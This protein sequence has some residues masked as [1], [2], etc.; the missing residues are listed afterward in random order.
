MEISILKKQ[1]ETH[2][3]NIPEINSFVFSL[4]EKMTN[5]NQYNQKLVQMFSYAF[6]EELVPLQ[7]EQENYFKQS[8]YNY[9]LKINKQKKLWESYNM[10]VFVGVKAE[11]KVVYKNKENLT[12]ELDKIFTDFPN[13]MRNI[14][15][16]FNI[17]KI[18]L[19]DEFL[20]INGQLPNMLKTNRILLYSS[21]LNNVDYAELASAGLANNGKIAGVSVLLSSWSDLCSEFSFF[22]NEVSR[23]TIHY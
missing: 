4:N 2:L 12:K 22:I 17:E 19:V 9:A 7:T 8:I 21:L 16:I 13:K 11:G 20:N 3:Q 15:S 5:D 6:Y 1:L 10:N 14:K 23:R 18:D